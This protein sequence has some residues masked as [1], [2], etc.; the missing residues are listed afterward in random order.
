LN[1][2]S[3]VRNGIGFV[4]EVG[5]TDTKRIS[6]CQRSMEFAVPVDYFTSLFLVRFFFRRTPDLISPKDL[7]VHGLSRRRLLSVT[8]VREARYHRARQSRAIE[9][10]R[11]IHEGRASRSL[12]CIYRSRS[13]AV[14]SRTRVRLSP[15]TVKFPSGVKALAA[16]SKVR[17]AMRVRGQRRP[18]P[19]A[20]KLM[21]PPQTSWKLAHQRRCIPASARRPLQ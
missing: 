14:Q 1:H 2:Y 3:L 12:H 13:D 11:A 15:H 19:L 18:S 21:P 20:A 9:N 17:L 6:A 8:V 10:P 7:L 4:T 5:T 16:H